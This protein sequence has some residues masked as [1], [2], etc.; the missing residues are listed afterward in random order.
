MKHSDARTLWLDLRKRVDWDRAPHLHAQLF[1]SRWRFEFRR[2]LVALA[3][4]A[5]PQTA[6]ADLATTLSSG[7]YPRLNHLMAYKAPED[8]HWLELGRILEQARAD[9]APLWAS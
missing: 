7:E 9:R 2:E 3:V 1:S 8:P 6:Q 4:F 5:Q